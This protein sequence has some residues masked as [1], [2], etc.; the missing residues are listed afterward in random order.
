MDMVILPA[1]T[2]ITTTNHPDPLKMF[3]LHST[4]FLSELIITPDGN[5]VVFL[6]DDCPAGLSIFGRKVFSHDIKE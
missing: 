3:I 6:S 1:T 2:I 5:V 4:A